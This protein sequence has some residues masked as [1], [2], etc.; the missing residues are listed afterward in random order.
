MRII[1]LSALLLVT[2]SS[3]TLP[4]GKNEEAP[5]PATPVAT[6]PA[7]TPATPVVEKIAANGNIVSLNYTLHDGAPD[8]KIL[9]TTVATVAQAAGTFSTGT[10]YQ[11]FQVQLG[12]NSVIVGFEKGLLG[13]KKGEKKLIPVSPE[14]GYGTGA[15]LQEIDKKQIAPVFTLT[16]PKK[17]FADTV[18][19]TVKKDQLN[20]EM[21]KLTLG[22]TLTGANGATAKVT[23]VEA[24]SMTF[25]I[26]NVDNPFYK[27][28][29]KVGATADNVAASFKITAIEGD[30]VTVEVTNKKSPFYGK[31][32]EVG[33][34]ISLPQGGSVTIAA[35]GDKTV[36]IGEAHPLAGKTLFF[37]VEVVDVQ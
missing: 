37:D 26:Q 32:F 17:D 13:M 35:I 10:T 15:R 12:S 5:T 8:G 7:P 30:Q 4:F 24:D 28:T 20:E 2:L 23:A 18:T 3:C 31:K 34:S 1:T 19:E 25:E 36:T 22:Q 6:T 29:L 14:E 11:P 33:E 21:K 27:Q 16:Q 9:E